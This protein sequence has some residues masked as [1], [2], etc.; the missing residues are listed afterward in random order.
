VFSEPTIAVRGVRLGTIGL[1]GGSVEV[2]AVVANP[3]PFALTA[4]R[5]RYRFL[6]R[7]SVEVGNGEITE[8]FSVGARD[9]TRI[10]LP[11]DV[12]FRG[13]R[14]TAREAAADGT[15]AYRVVGDVVMDTPMGD[16]TFPFDQRGR[17]AVR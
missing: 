15:I 8:Q 17:M 3:N 6:V 1:S 7:D 11:I 5:A 10:T 12:N 4:R 14:A 16:R 2:V 13:L 9:S